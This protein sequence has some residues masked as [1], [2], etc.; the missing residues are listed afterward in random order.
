MV[1]HSRIEDV[2]EST[3]LHAFYDLRSEH[4]FS[5]EPRSVDLESAESLLAALAQHPRHP[6]S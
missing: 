6:P 5:A 3:V 1:R 4:D 2:V